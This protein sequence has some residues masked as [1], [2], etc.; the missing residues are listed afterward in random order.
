GDLVWNDTNANGI[1]DS[2]E[3]GLDGVTVTLYRPGFGAD[4]IAGNA[5]DALA[6]A[7]ATTAGG[8][9]YS[10]TGLRPGTYEVNFGAFAGY[11]RTLALQGGDTN[12]DSNAN[13]ATG[14]TAT[15][16]VA[17]GATNNS[18]DA[19]YFQPATIGDLVWND[20]NANGIRDSGE[21]GINGVT[22]TLYRPGFGADGIAGNADDALAVAT[23]T[24]SGGGLYSFSGLRPGTYQ[25]N[26][27]ALSGYSYTLAT[28]GSDT[29]ID[30]DA[31][32][33]T[34][35]T[36]S[37]SVA[38]GV[39]NNSIDAGYFQGATIG[40]LVWND[41]NANGIRDSGELGLDGVTV[42]LYRPGF[43]ADGISGNADDALA[44]ATTTTAGGGLYSFSGL[45]PGTYEVN[46]G[47]L[48]G[49]NRTL[50]LQG[51]DINV[52]SNAN[53]TTGTTAT[54]AVAAGVTNNTI[55]AGYFQPAT[56]G[57]LVWN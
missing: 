38:A 52:D 6:V 32:P 26:F 3:L 50:A 34:G 53:A 23:A 19:G 1:R 30:S 13:A 21:L 43:G 11:A 54:F 15:F 56:I 25:V 5:D 10:F 14:T 42:T 41:V 27:G 17:A 57:D 16:A 48:A 45:R 40:D 8:G 49:Y 51:S 47:A 33:L 35:T 4:G 22:V 18:I 39:T 9:L 28:Q 2:G 24:T 7:T 46:F 44:V 29:N 31:N 12:V 36:A 37:F 55:D 20:A